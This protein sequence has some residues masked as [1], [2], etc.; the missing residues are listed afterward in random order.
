MMGREVTE[1][2]EQ[3]TECSEVVTREQVDKVMQVAGLLV[4]GELCDGQE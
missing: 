3:V 4:R 2:L 1:V